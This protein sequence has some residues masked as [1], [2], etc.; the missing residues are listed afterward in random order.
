[1]P[2]KRGLERRSCDF[3][4]RRKIK[5][6]RL[7]RAT[8]GFEKCSPCNVRGRRCYL[9]NSSDMRIQRRP[10][11]TPRYDDV[12]SGSQ[13]LP[14]RFSKTGEDRDNHDRRSESLASTPRPGDLTL[15]EDGYV[16]SPQWSTDFFFNTD[17]FALSNDSV[18]F[19][20]QVFMS[21]SLQT[22]WTAGMPMMNEG[23]PTLEANNATHN[24]EDGQA[25][26]TELR[27]IK[28][29]VLGDDAGIITKALHAYFDYAA[30]YLPILIAD[31]FWTDFH[32]GRC[33]PTLLFAVACRG[34]P[35]TNAE[36]KWV[37]QEQL[38]RTFRE[39]FLEA[40]AAALDDDGAIG[41]DDLEALALMLDFQYDDTSG[42]PLHTNLGRLFLTHESLVL[43]M[44]RSHKHEYDKP[45]AQ[46]PSGRLTRASERR[47]LLYWHVYGLDAFDC[48][49][50][51]QQSLIPDMD[52]ATNQGNTPLQ[53]QAKDYFD[54]VLGL[55]IIA[56]KILHTL[57]SAAAKHNGV[58]PRHVR[59]MYEALAHWR[60][61]SCPSHLR[62]S[63]DNGRNLFDALNNDNNNYNNNNNNNNNNSSSSSNSSS[64]TSNL[65]PAQERHL[66]LRRAVLCALEF[67]CT[68]QIEACVSVSRLHGDDELETEQVALQIDFESVRALNEM[69][70]LCKWMRKFEAE[71]G[72]STAAHQQ[73]HGLI[74][75]APNILRNACAGFCYWTCQRG[76][77]IC[78]RQDD[79]PHAFQAYA[80]SG[81]SKE[82][83]AKMWMKEA[84]LLRDC[85]A[86][87]V[88]H[89]DTAQVLKRLDHQ[90][91]LLQALLERL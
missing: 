83:R 87:A 22:E 57:C 18:L 43:M 89:K 82:E 2:L 54:A 45:N 64:S 21:E 10:T 16:R 28:T 77:D 88:S 51:K 20:D 37:F 69:Q 26:A 73:Q 36:N 65:A 49:D 78:G 76:I 85:V 6:D 7:T 12:V 58:S 17:D 86:T 74:D 39:S 91:G 71:T 75:L 61:H 47:V 1:M 55:A 63:T 23:N 48:L 60:S 13:A 42:P 66:Q 14:P 72:G 90:L 11:I 70:Q 3:C 30:L 79:R 4:F 53:H 33:S 62:R 68:M 5:C 8:Q 38:A 27:R 56:R 19:L 31:A 44:L 67:N 80:R 15:V 35:F 50:R 40:R 24:T 32:A 25:T 9:D 52:A 46:S 29:P 34:M 41:L 59:L 84:Q 81:G